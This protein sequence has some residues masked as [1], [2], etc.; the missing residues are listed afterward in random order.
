MVSRLLQTGVSLE[1]LAK[2]APGNQGVPLFVGWA[3][4]HGMQKEMLLR[5]MW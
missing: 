2:V 5:R 4:R 1:Q 3:E